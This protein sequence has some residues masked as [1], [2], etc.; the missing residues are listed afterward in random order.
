MSFPIQT[1]IRLHFHPPWIVRRIPEVDLDQ[2]IQHIP[3]LLPSINIYKIYIN[4]KSKHIPHLPLSSNKPKKSNFKGVMCIPEA[5]AY[6][7]THGPLCHTLC[8]PAIVFID[9]LFVTICL[10]IW[11]SPR[12]AA[13]SHRPKFVGTYLWL[14]QAH[15]VL[16]GPERTSPDGFAIPTVVA[17][18]EV[19][20]NSISTPTVLH[21]HNNMLQSCF[22]SCFQPRRRTEQDHRMR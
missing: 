9:N 7:F 5:I 16:A 21:L 15:S 12:R 1:N 3:Q 19:V 13:S 14:T 20:L 18:V 17:A 10:F 4:F 8:S 11:Y 22:A 6:C 2:V